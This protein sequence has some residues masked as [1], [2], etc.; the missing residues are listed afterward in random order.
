M[1]VKRFENR[2]NKSN[3][4]FNTLNP[5]WDTEKEDAINVFEMID[6]LN[7]LSEENEWLKQQLTHCRKLLNDDLDIALEFIKHK[8]YSLQDLKDYEK[9][10]QND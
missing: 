8:G 1:T 5:T 10:M 6:L 2:L 9:A 7:N 4:K 3:I